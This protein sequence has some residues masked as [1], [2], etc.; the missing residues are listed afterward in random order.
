ML[1]AGAKRRRTTGQ[2]KAE[3][4]AEAKHQQEIAAKLAMFDSMK[5]EN[6][7]LHAQ[8]QNN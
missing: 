4:E 2:I 8:V 3:K 1:K 7:Q 5:A 6:Q